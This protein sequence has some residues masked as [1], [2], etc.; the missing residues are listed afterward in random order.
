VAYIWPCYTSSTVIVY[1]RDKNLSHS[2]QKVR[3]GK[4]ISEIPDKCYKVENMSEPQ[5]GRVPIL[6]LK[7]GATETKGKDARKNSITAAKLIAQVI[8]SSLGP[9][10]M[11]KMSSILQ[12][13]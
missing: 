8:R 10:G 9:R 2:E 4:L 3:L 6:L 12:R 7:D 5:Q 13:M 1:S 11:D